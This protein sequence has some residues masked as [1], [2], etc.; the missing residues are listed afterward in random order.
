MSETENDLIE[1]ALS[2][3]SELDAQID[4]L[5]AERAKLRAFVNQICDFAGRAPMFSKDDDR[6]NAPPNANT[7]LLPTNIAS[8]RGSLSIKPD[9]FYKQPL[10]TAARRYLEMRKNVEL[11]PASADEIYD[12]LVRGGFE[13]P[14]RDIDN[15]KRGLQVS[16]SKNTLVFRKLPNELYGLA[17]WYR[18]VRR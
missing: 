3:L 14:S 18:G 16:L 10:A 12:A 15:Q 5:Q 2:K 1:K 7:D 4:D 6:S 8:R 17:D 11:G 13:F 9:E